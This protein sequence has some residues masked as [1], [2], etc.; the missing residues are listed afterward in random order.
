MQ[1][2][3]VKLHKTD[4][5]IEATDDEDEEEQPVFKIL[6]ERRITIVIYPRSFTPSPL[7]RVQPNKL[8][9]LQDL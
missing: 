1:Y 4:Y 6:P 7:Q 5:L 8:F 3:F 9:F 2:T